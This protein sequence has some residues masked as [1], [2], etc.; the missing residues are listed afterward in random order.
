MQLINKEYGIRGGIIL[1]S[2]STTAQNR[3]HN[4]ADRKKHATLGRGR[5]AEDKREGKR[6]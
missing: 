6:Q 3:T 1:S 4:S 5:A 2:K